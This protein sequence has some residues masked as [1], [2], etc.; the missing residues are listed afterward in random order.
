M[1]FSFE[2]LTVIRK[3]LDCVWPLTVAAMAFSRV[4]RLY[5][6]NFKIDGLAIQQTHHALQ[7]THPAEIRTARFHR[8]RPWE[9]RHN[10]RNKLCDNRAAILARFFNH[11]D[12]IL[13]LF[14]VGANLRFGNIGYSCPAHKTC[15]GLFRRAYTR[16]LTFLRNIRRAQRNIGCKNQTPRPR[17]AMLIFNRQAG[18]FEPIGQRLRQV[19]SCPH[20]HTRRNLF[21][22]YFK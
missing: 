3:A 9:I 5:T 1:A 6:A 21:A 18:L 8:F 4:A 7:R 10:G 17:I 11:G 15:K 16:P 22:E 14:R 2:L 13:A 19:L 20:L 12:I